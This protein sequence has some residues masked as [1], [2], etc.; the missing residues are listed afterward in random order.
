MKILILDIETSP[1]ILYGF[2]LFKQNFGINQIEEPTRMICFAAQWL[3]DR[4][5]MFFSEYHDGRQEMV[6][7]AY[8]LL[9]EADAVITYNGDGFDIPHMNREFLEAGLT[10]PSPYSSIDLLKTVRKQFRNASNKLDWIVQHLGIGAK[11]THSG[12]Q[13]WLDCLRG[14]AKAWALMKRYNIQDVRVTGKLYKRLLPWIQPHPNVALHDGFTSGCGNCG[15]FKFTREGTAKTTMGVFQ[16]YRCK[17][18][19]KYCRGNTRILGA[20]KVGLK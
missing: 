20:T 1:H 7:A 8:K 12:F 2:G 4:D 9:D 13:L 6:N 19:G 11:T 3:G 5:V 17:N 14:D 10:P 16:R 15:S 18:C